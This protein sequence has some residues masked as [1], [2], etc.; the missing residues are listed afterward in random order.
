M[1]MKKNLLFGVLF[2]GLAATSVGTSNAECVSGAACSIND[3]VPQANSLNTEI[4]P[5]SVLPPRVDEINN[6][7]SS[8]AQRLIDQNRYDANCQFGVCLPSQNSELFKS[9]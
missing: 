9:E 1:C 2:L 7:R 8:N 5:K 6:D 3:V 4:R